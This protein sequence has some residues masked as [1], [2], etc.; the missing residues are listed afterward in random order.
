MYCEDYTLFYETKLYSNERCDSLLTMRSLLK[1]DS[2]GMLFYTNKNYKEIPI[3]RSNR[4]S[5]TRG[6]KTRQQKQYDNP[7]SYRSS[8]GSHQTRHRKNLE[9]LTQ[10]NK[11]TDT[12]TTPSQIQPGLIAALPDR[13]KQHVRWSDDRDRSRSQDRY[14]RQGQ[15][16]S[17]GRAYN[18]G[19]FYSR[20]RLP[21]PGSPQEKDQYSN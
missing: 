11:Q 20:A 5:N 14:E 10:L 16:Q 21:S 18:T 13:Q 15:E 1:F 4:G 7:T 12:I 8:T 17:P 2:F 3:C 6:R 19:R 9:K